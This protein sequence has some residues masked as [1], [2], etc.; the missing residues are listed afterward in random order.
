[1]NAVADGVNGKR[2]VSSVLYGIDIA[3]Q[4]VRL[5]SSGTSRPDLEAYLASLLFEIGGQTQKRSFRSPSLTTEFCNC[6]Q[7]FYNSRDLTV[8]QSCETLANRLLRHEIQTEK[9][10]PNINQ[11]TRGSFL[12]FIYEENG[13]VSY[14]GVK[15]EHQSFLDEAD[16]I[17]K[18]GLADDR[19]LYKACQVNFDANGI[20]IEFSVFDTNGLPA[21]YWWREFLELAVVRD[22]TENTKT[23]IEAVLKVLGTIKRKHPSDHTVLRNATIAP[24]KQQG[25][26]NYVDF[27]NRLFGSYTPME[28]EAIVLISSLLPRLHELPSKKKFDTQFNLIPEAVP[29]R[30][31]KYILS[32]EISLTIKDGI[33]NLSTKIWAEKTA[34]GREVVVIESDQAHVFGFKA[35]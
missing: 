35:R 28:T 12:Q 13:T 26:M 7:S 10:Y 3:A 33:E 2:I 17:K 34:D 19:K 25:P 29:Y 21:A 11:I 15:V 30:Q 16:L 8:D 22:D 18:F 32:P 27:I 9:R 20:P 24:F 14:L 1:M 4:S 31:T 23:A 6:L 5:V